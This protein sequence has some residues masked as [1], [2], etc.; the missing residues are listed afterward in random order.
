M[1]GQIGPIAMSLISVQNLSLSLHQTLFA[2][3]D[4]VVGDGERLGIVAANGRG[5]TSLLRLIVGEGSPPAVR[6]RA[7][8]G[9]K[10]AMSASMSQT[11]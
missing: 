8:V 10:S 7:R 2:N 4:F 1:L 6:S 5:K 9:S 3:L 11:I